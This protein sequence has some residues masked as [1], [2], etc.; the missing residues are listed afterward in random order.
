MTKSLDCK[1]ANM[2]GLHARYVL[3][4]LALTDPLELACSSAADKSLFQYVLYQLAD[5][6]SCY[7]TVVMDCSYHDDL[8]VDPVVLAK[9]YACMEIH[10][11]S[12]Y[13]PKELSRKELDSYRV[14]L[15]KIAALI[16]DRMM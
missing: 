12:M 5:V 4:D 13:E 14:T 7:K 3:R 16:R 11:Q 9:Y 2:A 10:R 15:Y 8:K 6:V 1:G